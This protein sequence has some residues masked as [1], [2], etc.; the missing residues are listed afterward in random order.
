MA[1]AT[2]RLVVVDDQPVIRSGLAHELSLNADFLVVAQAHDAASAIAAWR[3][4]HPDVCLLNATTALLEGIEMTRQ[5]VEAFPGARV[6]MLTSSSDPA[7]IGLAMRAGAIGCLT[8]SIGHEELAEAIRGAS[9]GERSTAVLPAAS[10]RLT[11]GPLSPRKLEVLALIRQGYSNEE[12]AARLGVGERTIRFHYHGHP[13][14]PPRRRQGAGR[15]HRF[16]TRPFENV[17]QEWPRMI[18]CPAFR[19]APAALSWRARW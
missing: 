11:S 19:L 6:L 16:R 13:R 5:V 4:Q 2:I 12:I 17:F 14:H 8:K 3:K 1:A 9:R 7:D 18:R 10:A 15:G